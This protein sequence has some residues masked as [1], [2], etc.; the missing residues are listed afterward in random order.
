LYGRH[1]DAGRQSPNWA[2]SEGYKKAIEILLPLLAEGKIKRPVA[3]V[4][5]FEQVGAAN[6]YLVEDRPFGK[7][8]LKFNR[9]CG[10]DK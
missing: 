4:F 8:L 5:P 9:Q 6:K 10:Y 3:K 1:T 7:V 2:D